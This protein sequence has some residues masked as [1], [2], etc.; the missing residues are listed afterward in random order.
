MPATKKP[1]ARKPAR[2]ARAAPRPSFHLP[3]LEQRQ[4]DLIGLALVAL[5]LFFGFL[6]YFGW[7]GGRAGSQAVE[8]LRWL[9]GAGHYLVPVALAAAGAILMLRPVLPAVRPFRSGA[10]CV[11]VRRDARAFGRDARLGPGGAR[12]D[13]WDATWVKTRGGMVGETLDWGVET[14]AGLVGAHILAVFL[15]IAGVLLLT[16]AS[17]AGVIKFT[18]DSVSTT[19]RELRGAV[20]TRAPAARPTTWRRWSVPRACASSARGFGEPP[21]FERPS[22]RAAKK[23]AAKEDETLL[24]RRRALPGPL[25]K[26]ARARAGAGRRAEPSPR[27]AGARAARRGPGR[28]RAGRH[29][30][31]RPSRSSPSSSRRRAA[32]APRSPTRRTSS[33]SSRTP[34]SSPAPP[35]TPRARTRPARRRSRRSCWRRSGT[36]TSRRA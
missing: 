30:R 31:A 9:L 10:I 2:A 27:R 5:A 20:K 11:F 12:P 29:A 14:L 35:R 34:P 19:T 6:V 3:T 28:G 18:S 15:F 8:G 13:W 23:K 22:P 25:R 7:D 4:L 26:R 1:A 32:T 16:G 17:V 24:V 21:E 33:G 36:S